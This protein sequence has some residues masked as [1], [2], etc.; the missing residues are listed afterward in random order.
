MELIEKRADQHW[1]V[2]LY[3]KG[4]GTKSPEAG[5]GLHGEGP[6]ST[7]DREKILQ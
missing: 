6:S 5:I 3:K 1:C 4:G 7:E 2:L